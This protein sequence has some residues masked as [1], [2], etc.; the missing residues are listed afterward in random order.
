MLQFKG[1]CDF[2][3]PFASDLLGAFKHVVSGLGSPILGVSCLT[4]P[5]PLLPG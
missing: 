3:R 2:I 4:V 1:E 5:P